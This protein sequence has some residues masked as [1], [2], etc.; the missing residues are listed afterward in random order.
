MRKFSERK[1]W[2]KKNKFRKIINI[3]A[4][5]VQY[6]MYSEY[7]CSLTNPNVCA[8]F[9]VCDGLCYWKALCDIKFSQID[10]NS[11]KSIVTQS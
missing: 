2:M 9:A 10:G 11:P 4:A 8:D 5:T 6:S 7:T 1:G 3:T